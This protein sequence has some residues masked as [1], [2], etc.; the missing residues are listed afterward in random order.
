MSLR[1]EFENALKEFWMTP[2]GLELASPMKQALWAAKWMAE[3]CA[4]RVKNNFG[5]YEI[6]ME[7]SKELQ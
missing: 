7:L 4:E 2:D 1:E 6:L 3:R 5:A